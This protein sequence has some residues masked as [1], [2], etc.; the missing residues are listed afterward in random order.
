MTPD[1]CVGQK[2][3]RIPPQT[4]FQL[5]LASSPQVRKWPIR[6]LRR[7]LTAK[8]GRER[9]GR[10]F[11]DMDDIFMCSLQSVQK[12]LINDKR[13]FELY[14]YDILLDEALRP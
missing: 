9:V 10:L 8:H 13:C 5:L 7:Y 11:E 2:P 4:C 1:R 14:G 12:V 3:Q 6:Q